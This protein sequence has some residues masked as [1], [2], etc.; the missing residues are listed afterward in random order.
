MREREG[1]KER[2]RRTIMGLPL[3]SSV[4][5]GY[6]HGNEGYKA[7]QSGRLRDRERGERLGGREKKK[8]AEERT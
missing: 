7:W 4:S 3:S 5:G 6:R 8:T 2:L 1:R